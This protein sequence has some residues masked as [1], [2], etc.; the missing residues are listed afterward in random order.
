MY[1]VDIVISNV[2]N[3]NLKNILFFYF[4]IEKSSREFL[5]LFIHLYLMLNYFIKPELNTVKLTIFMKTILLQSLE[6]STQ[7]IWTQQKQMQAQ[8]KVCGLRRSRCKLNPKYMDS[9]KVDAS[10]TQSIWTQEKQMQAQ[11]KVYGLRKSRCK[12]NRKYMDSGEVEEKRFFK[13][14]N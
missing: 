7:S 8:P 9:G 14:S 10:S 5:F 2:L 6:F 12:L 13:N 3:L 1:S 11:P 4:S